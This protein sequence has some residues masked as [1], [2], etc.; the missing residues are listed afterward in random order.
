MR[1]IISVILVLIFVPRISVSALANENEVERVY[2]EDGSYLEITIQ[3]V[4]SR[5]SGTK[6]AGKTYSF[7]N[8]NG[9]EEWKAVL[10][11]TFT[12]TGS[13]AT[14]IA[15]SCD[16]TITD[17]AWYE[18]SKVV[19]KSGATAT[20]DLTMGRKLLGITIEKKTI[21]MT[22]TCDANGNLS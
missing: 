6:S 7:T 21:N 2:F 13:S 3:S 19:N 17:T 8:S 11:A 10:R 14:C 9:V 20:C 12:Y 1:R 18:V 4:E 15:S 16:V 22:F 5:A